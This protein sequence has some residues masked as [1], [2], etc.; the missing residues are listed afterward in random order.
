VEPANLVIVIGPPAVGKMTVGRALARLC[1]MG[2]FHNHASI[3]PFL[4]VFEYGSASFRRLSSG[5][6]SRVFE[7]AATTGRSLVF[8]YVWAFDSPSD[9][10]AIDA[11][12]KIFEDVGGKVFFVELRATQ[13]TRLARNRTA[14]RLRAKPSKLDVERSDR[15]VRVVDE[16]H[17]LSSNGDFPYPDRHLVVQ[18]EDLTP[19]EAARRIRDHFGLPSAPP[20]VERLGVEDADR[21]RTLRLRA[22]QEA[23]DAFASTY[24]ETARRPPESWRTALADL[25]TF[26]AVIDGEDV[27]MVRG[28]PSSDCADDAFL[29]SMWVAPEARGTGM[30]E[31][32]VTAVVDW[33]RDAGFSRVVLEVGDHNAQAIAL[34]ERMGFEPTGRTGRSDDV[35]RRCGARCGAMAHV[36]TLAALSIR[37]AR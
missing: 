3:E 10:E 23:P 6:R 12:S 20:R 34:Y 4:E 8:T 14:E 19:L 26:F 16:Q 30:G 15:Y 13:Q 17:V 29:L 36:R 28:A 25:A 27:G 5:M 32:L 37:I 9:R 21:L 7:E 22:L 1:G 11:W 2:L 33:A 31:S 24:E 35:Q 18:T